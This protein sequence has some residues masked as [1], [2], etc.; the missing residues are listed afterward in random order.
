MYDCAVQGKVNAVSAEL[1][2]VRAESKRKE[3]RVGRLARESEKKS[4][5]Q[6]DKVG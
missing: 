4:Q 3:E 2:K 1:E 6:T 5:T